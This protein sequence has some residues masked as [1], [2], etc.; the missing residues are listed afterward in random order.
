MEDQLY[1]GSTETLIHGLAY[2]GKATAAYVKDRTSATYFPTGG[3]AYSPSGVRLLRFELV[4]NADDFLDPASLRLGFTLVNN[5]ADSPLRLL[6]NDPLVVFQRLR[7][8]ARG[9]LI[10]DINYLH[11]TVEMFSILLP[12]QRRNTLSMQMMGDVVGRDEALDI[13]SEGVP[14]KQNQVVGFSCRCPPAS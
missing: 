7:V 3:N 10:E 14:P 12:P 9:Q 5:D 1:Q 13:F 2:S 6:S 8:L 4:T 11:R